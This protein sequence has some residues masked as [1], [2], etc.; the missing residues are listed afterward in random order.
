VGRPRGLAGLPDAHSGPAFATLAGLVQFA[1]SDPLD[2]RQVQNTQQTI[3]RVSPT[4]MVQRL[5][6]AFRSSY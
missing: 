5:I 4:G 3:H 1:G 6:A 2:L